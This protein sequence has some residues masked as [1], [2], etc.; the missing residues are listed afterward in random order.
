M[1]R[2]RAVNLY[3]F[4]EHV[5]GR[6]GYFGNDGAFLT[7]QGIEQAGFTRIGPANDG[8]Y[9]PVPQQSSLACLVQQAGEFLA[10]LVQTLEY[11]AFSQEINF[12]VRKIYRCLDKNT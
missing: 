8:Q 7:G 12:F 5:P 9:N 10:G 2:A 1:P 3:L 6:A 11:I 4:P